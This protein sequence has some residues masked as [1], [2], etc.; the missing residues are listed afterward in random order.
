MKNLKKFLALA[1]LTITTSSQ[2]FAMQSSFEG[3]AT[4]KIP[5]D[6]VPLE[7]D[8]VRIETGDMGA[9]MYKGQNNASLLQAILERR[10]FDAG[11]LIKKQSKCK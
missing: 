10:L 7:A 3:C 2:L 9:V 4:R 1:F 6:F 5:E 11:N 8:M